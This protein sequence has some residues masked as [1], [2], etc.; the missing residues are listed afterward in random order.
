MPKPHA[1]EMR[2]NGWISEDT[3][4]LDNKRVSTGR[5]P[6]KYQAR[7]WRLSRAIAASLKGGRRRRVKAAGAEVDTLLG[8]NPPMPQE[9][10]QR[11]KGWYKAAVDRAPPPARVTLGRITA[12]RVDLYSYVPSPGTNFPI[13]VNPVPVDSSVPT[14]DEMEGSVNVYVETDPGG[15]RGRGTST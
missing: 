10:W 2:K 4:R 12:E 7:I 8:L 15:R 14:E 3:W 11:I 9:S 6:A 5:N 1:R 13:Y